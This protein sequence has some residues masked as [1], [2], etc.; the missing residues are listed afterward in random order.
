MPEDVIDAALTAE[1]EIG[2][3]AEDLANAAVMG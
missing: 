1:E 3:S 2:M